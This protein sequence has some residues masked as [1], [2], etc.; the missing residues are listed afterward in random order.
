LLPLAVTETPVTF[1]VTVSLVACVVQVLTVKL[2]IAVY[3]LPAV[4]N[5][6]LW[7]TPPDMVAV[8]AAPEPPA[9]VKVKFCVPLV[10]PIPPK[11]LAAIV[12]LLGDNELCELFV[13][14]VIEPA[15]VLVTVITAPARVAV[16]L[17]F[18]TP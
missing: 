10:Q 12:P 2:G 5:V 8:P 11:A 17:V 15:V 7:T 16:T 13:V 14:K 4:P 18:A 6:T 1:T 9:P 3:P